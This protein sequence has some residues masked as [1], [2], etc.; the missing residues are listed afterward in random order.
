MLAVSPILIF[1]GFMRSLRMAKNFRG[2]S[3]EFDG[4]DVLT[5]A[6]NNMRVVRSLNC[7][8]DMVEKFRKY[9]EDY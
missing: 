4:A 1:T 5:D 9:D 2:K 6:I 3:N 8:E 7:E